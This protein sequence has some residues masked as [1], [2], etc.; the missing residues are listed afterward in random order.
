MKLLGFN[1][2]KKILNNNDKKLFKKW[3]KLREKK[4][5]KKADKIQ[6]ELFDKK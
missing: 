3:N 1:F 4:K 6:K 2:S 5:Y